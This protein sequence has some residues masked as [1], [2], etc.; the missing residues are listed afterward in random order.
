MHVVDF[1][2]AN[3][4]KRTSNMETYL[5]ALYKATNYSIRVVAYT[6]AGDGLSSSPVY[7]STEDDGKKITLLTISYILLH[8]KYFVYTYLA[9]NQ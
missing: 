2:S 9:E 1:T 4:V 8:I 5:H 3:E 7:C 6:I